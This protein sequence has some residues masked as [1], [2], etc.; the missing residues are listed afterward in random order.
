[1]SQLPDSHIYLFILENESFLTVF[2]VCGR[3]LLTQN[4]EYCSVA[5]LIG[6]I[7]VSSIV[8]EVVIIPK[9]SNH[10]CLSHSSKL[11]C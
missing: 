11:I 9:P 3:A 1:M 6:V 4:L 7:A 10:R 8:L 5:V 2:S